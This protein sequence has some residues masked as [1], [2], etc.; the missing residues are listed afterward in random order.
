MKVP[1][2]LSTLLVLLLTACAAQVEGLRKD[3]S[4]TYLAAKEGGLAIGGVTS[5]LE[6]LPATERSRYAGVLLRA[7]R[8]E[9][10]TFRVHPAGEVVAAL[11]ER[12]VDAMLDFYRRHGVLAAEDL[13][14]LTPQRLGA[15]YLVLARIERDDVRQEKNESSMD[16]VEYD[17]K[18][19]ARPTKRVEVTVIH[20]TIRTVS[21]SFQIYDLA[22]DRSVW[23]GVITQHATRSNQTS[24]Q[25]GK[26]ERWS[27]ELLVE[28]VRQLL[29]DGKGEDP[30]PKPAAFIDVLGQVFTGFAENLPER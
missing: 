12:R 29:L 23:S 20:D 10:E 15:R 30:Y 22:S 13:A 17:D 19:N 27:Q 21:A 5:T 8:E 4:F 1:Y 6:P 24:Q 28:L 25:F 9:R 11:G 26:D 16:V 14:R 3:D 18:G 7:T 2:I